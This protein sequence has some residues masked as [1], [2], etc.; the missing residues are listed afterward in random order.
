MSAKKNRNL[1]GTFESLLHPVEA[2]HVLL[3]IS[4]LH[5]FY[6]PRRGS[7]GGLADNE[8]LLPFPVFGFI[9]QNQENIFCTELHSLV[10]FLILC[11]YK[12]NHLHHNNNNNR[13]K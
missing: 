6:C 12:N 4:I 1:R 11:I 9:Q 7:H 2:A 8:L 10:N 3:N 13:N 5:R